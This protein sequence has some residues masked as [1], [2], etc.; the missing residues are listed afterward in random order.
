MNIWILLAHS[1]FCISGCPLD[2]FLLTIG[3]NIAAFFRIL[4]LFAGLLK[5]L[6]NFLTIL[7]MSR[8]DQGLI[9]LIENAS[10]PTLRDRKTMPKL[11][12]PKLNVTVSA[13]SLTCQEKASFLLDMALCSNSLLL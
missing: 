2:R 3:R 10:A 11:V 13:S 5:A 4:F 12:E 8:K 7:R 6:H 1:L 9:V